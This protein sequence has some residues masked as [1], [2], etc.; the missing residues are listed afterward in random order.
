MQ[1]KKSERSDGRENCTWKEILCS[2]FK[3]KPEKREDRGKKSADSVNSAEVDGKDVFSGKDGRGVYFVLGVLGEEEEETPA[4]PTSP[5]SA[6]AI[7][8]SEMASK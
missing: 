6:I 4:P 5:F 1:E 2:L 8:C 7:A 3:D